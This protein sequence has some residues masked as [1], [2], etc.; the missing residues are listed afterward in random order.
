MKMK[1]ISKKVASEQYG[2]LTNG[3][4]TLYSY[5]LRDDGCVVDSGGDIRYYPPDYLSEESAKVFVPEDMPGHITLDTFPD[6]DDDY[7]KKFIVEK[8]WMFDALQNSLSHNENEPTTL[9]N[10]LYN[11]VWEETEVIYD[12]AKQQ[13]KLV[14]EW[15]E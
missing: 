9:E 1:R 8:K 10:F 2:V 13:G 14:K 15:H 5:Y 6:T 12:L 11:Y 3:V 4:N 7:C